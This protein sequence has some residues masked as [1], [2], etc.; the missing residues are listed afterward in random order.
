MMLMSS[1]FFAKSAFT[2]PAAEKST[3][4][5]KSVSITRSHDQA[6]MSTN[7]AD[8][9]STIT[10]IIMPLMTPPVM[11]PEMTTKSGMGATRISS[12]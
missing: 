8:V 12:R 2:S 1:K 7:M 5:R 4:E 3:E 11:N 10:A 9:A 6:E